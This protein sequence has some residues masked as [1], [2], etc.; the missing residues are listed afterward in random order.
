M[1][2]CNCYPSLV[3]F[4]K[5]SGSKQIVERSLSIFPTQAYWVETD[6]RAIQ[7]LVEEVIT[8]THVFSLLR[9]NT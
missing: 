5:G 9:D 4:S 2:R 6:I 3:L 7:R 8:L 1:L